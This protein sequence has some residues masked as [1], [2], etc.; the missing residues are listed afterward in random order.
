M[1]LV[2][3][4]A[5]LRFW[6]YRL[7]MATVP[8]ICERCGGIFGAEVLAGAHGAGIRLGGARVGPCPSCGGSGTVPEGTYD[9]IDET[10]RVVRDATMDHDVLNG[11]IELL[12]GRVSGT[13]SD[14]EVIERTEAQS[15]EL[16]STVRRFLS[17]SDPASWLQLL[18]TVLMMFQSLS[19]APPS[20]EEIAEAIWAR[21]HE[22]GTPTLESKRLTQPESACEQPP[23]RRSEAE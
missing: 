13:V 6:R 17:K 22:V 15:P 14:Q 5:S 18:L 12:E 23:E 20:A 1:L 2:S 16:G 10:L 3:P 4:D 7:R 19:S 21:E 11:L 8:A 9:L